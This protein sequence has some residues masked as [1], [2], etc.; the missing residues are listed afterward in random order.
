MLPRF[1]RF[2]VTASD[3]EAL[4]DRKLDDVGGLI[5]GGFKDIGAEIVEGVGC[6]D[7]VLDGAVVGGPWFDARRDRKKPPE[8]PLSRELGAPEAE[9]ERFRRWPDEVA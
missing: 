9:I 5:V 6:D 7:D 8:D 1:S 2:S 3:K 4:R